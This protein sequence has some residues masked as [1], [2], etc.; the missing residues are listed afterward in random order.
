MSL[1]L[2]AAKNLSSSGSVGLNLLNE[3]HHMMKLMQ[4]FAFVCYT[5]SSAYSTQ[6]QLRQPFT[7]PTF[8]KT[9]HMLNEAT[10]SMRATEKLSLKANVL[11]ATTP[12]NDSNTDK[13]KTGNKDTKASLEQLL[14]MKETL[15][16][17]V[18]KLFFFD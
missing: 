12:N 16:E 8:T 9:D 3:K 13:N 11:N 18:N 17:I 4:T 1:F 15:A 2:H 5:Q 7:A 10:L 6:N 14:L